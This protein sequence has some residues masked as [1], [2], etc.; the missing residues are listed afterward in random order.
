MC[1][2]CSY[3]MTIWQVLFE[4]SQLFLL[5]K[6]FT[7]FVAHLNSIYHPVV[8]SSMSNVVEKV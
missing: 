3:G 2:E 5:K 6:I 4:L 8:K 1:N 7:L